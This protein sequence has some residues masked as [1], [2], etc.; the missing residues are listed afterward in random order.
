VHARAP[1]LP[2][3]EDGN[4]PT[5]YGSYLSALMIYGFISETGVRTVAYRPDG[6]DEANV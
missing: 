6:V 1:G 3:Y 2:L 5:V 4:H